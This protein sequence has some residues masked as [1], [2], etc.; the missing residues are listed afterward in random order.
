MTP[1]FEALQIRYQ[2]LVA[3]SGAPSLGEEFWESVRIF[4]EDARQ[5]GRGLTDPG[6]R[7]LLRAYMRFLAVLLYEHGETPPPVELLPPERGR[8]VETPPVRRAEGG[9]P[10]WFWGLVGAAIMAV[11]A[12]LAAVLGAVGGYFAPQPTSLPV[13]PSPAM[14][15]AASPMWT[16]T[17]GLTPSPVPTPL[18]TLPPS[19][20]P[21]A[22]PAFGGLTIALGV[23]PTGEPILVGREFDWNT[24]AVYAIFDYTGMREGLPWSAVWTRNGREVARQAGF[25]DRGE[26]GRAW[27]VYF[28][29]DGTVLFGGD[30]GVSL[31]IGEQLQAESAFRI[32]YYIPRT[33]TP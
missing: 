5:A 1:I 22:P 18:P 28:N 16:P 13:S 32:R 15:V 30:Y 3:R 21:V 17:P 27:V 19:P 14:P 31:Y 23:L 29:P 4:L 12:G 11:I 8:W 24:R 6:E 9:F 20:T 2:D 7:A 25:W 26:R 10:A 33:P